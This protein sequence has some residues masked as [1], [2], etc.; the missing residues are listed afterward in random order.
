MK[1]HF[2]PA[3]LALL[4][5]FLFG[6]N[7]P[8]SKILLGTASPLFMVA[9]LYLGAGI[10]VLILQT[11]FRERQH[12]AQ[13]TRREMPW[14]I[15]MILLDVLAPF[16]LMCGL[17][18]TEAS[19]ASL[20]FNFEMVATTVIAS[21]FFKE[22]VGRRIWCAIGIITLASVILSIDFSDSTV[23]HF[24][25]GSLLVIG[26]CCCWGLENNCTRR[27]SA[28]SP[29]EI[30]ILKGFGSGGTALLIAFLSG[31]HFPLEWKTIAGGVLLGFV[32]Y[33]L[34]IYFYPKL[35]VF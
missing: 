10:G 28:K 7:A 27:L 25:P 22:A 19:N 20:L 5:A 35:R 11:I 6:L 2:Y 3:G 26:A 32:A 12:E 31:D 16:L 8:L 30:V 23:W 17:K 18:M 29:A 1:S 13:L 14:T 33:G 21:V 15:L 4:A 34:S 24:S 9:F